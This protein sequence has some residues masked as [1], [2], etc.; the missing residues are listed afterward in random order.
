[1]M[2]RLDL[3]LGSLWY[4]ERRVEDS[5]WPPLLLVHGAGA[6]HLDWP[7]ELR[8]LPGAW[9]LAPDLPGH[10]RSR[11]HS[12]RD[13]V[14]A[15][16]E[17]IAAFLDKLTLPR[18]IV[19]G[20]SMGGAIAQTLALQHPA[21]IAGLV[22]I[23]TGTRLRVHPDVLNNI[24]TEPGDVYDKIT[25]WMWA[26]SVPADVRDL[27]RGRLET[28]DPAVVHG[29]FQACNVFDTMDSV[30]QITAPTLVIGGTADKMTPLKF[31]TTLAAQI[32]G[33]E[34]VTIDG[35][36]HMMALEQPAAVADAVADWLARTDFS[37]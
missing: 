10:G 16:T 34:L 30:H 15:Y 20:H 32:P 14:D 21:R 26:E 12:G 18:V 36:G 25:A 3:P 8:R 5:A 7:A 13:T 22:L 17:D 1:M 19:I 28:N 35:G 24:L 37:G 33:A 2:P 9:T 4:A 29:D 6:S 31:S 23:G 27:G 11:P